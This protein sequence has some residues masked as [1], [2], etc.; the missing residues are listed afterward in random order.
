MGHEPKVPRMV[1]Q[2]R[3]EA[4]FCQKLR[5]VDSETLRIMWGD[6]H[7]EGGFYWR[8]GAGGWRW[9]EQARA[10]MPLSRQ[11]L[12]CKHWGATRAFDDTSSSVKDGLD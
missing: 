3:A 5:G 9:Q 12:F 4:A 6:W 8:L 2:P 1:F 7:V 10:L 11:V